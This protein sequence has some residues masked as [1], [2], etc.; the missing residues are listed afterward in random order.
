MDDIEVR[1]GK[2]NE[3]RRSIQC[4]LTNIFFTERYLQ[5]LSE[6]KVSGYLGQQQNYTPGVDGPKDPLIVESKYPRH[7]QHLGFKGTDPRV[8]P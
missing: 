8:S 7:G 1:T 5:L 3:L 6:G 2:R 4:V